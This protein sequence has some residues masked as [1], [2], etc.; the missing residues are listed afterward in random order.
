[1][2]DKKEGDKREVIP[3]VHE[4]VKQTIN[5]VGRMNTDIDRLYVALHLSETTKGMDECA[6]SPIPE[7]GSIENLE[8]DVAYLR[9]KIEAFENRL[10]RELNWLLGG[11]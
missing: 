3:D 8:Y 5:A 2:S 6:D 11:N 7:R 10:N 9:T 1:M 4:L